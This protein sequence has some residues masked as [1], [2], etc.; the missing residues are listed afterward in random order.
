MDRE[1]T[2]EN[3]DLMFQGFLGNSFKLHPFKTIKT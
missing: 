2:L 3:I 1:N